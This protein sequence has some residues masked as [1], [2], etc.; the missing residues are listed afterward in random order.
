[1]MRRAARDTIAW[2]GKVASF[3]SRQPPRAAFREKMHQNA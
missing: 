3:A 2:R 1:M